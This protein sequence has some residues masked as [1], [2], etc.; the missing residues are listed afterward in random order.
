[1]NNI[2]FKNAR[3]AIKCANSPCALAANLF[4]DPSFVDA[5]NVDFRVRFGSA[6]I[7]AG[8]PIDGL[9][10]DMTGIARPQGLGVDIGA[11]EYV[12]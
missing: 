4:S 6:A 7:D 11:Y 12:R 9:A 2:C 10:T 1:M 8:I 3:N 5:S